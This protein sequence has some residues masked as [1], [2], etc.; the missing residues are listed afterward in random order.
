MMKLFLIVYT[1]GNGEN[2]DQFVWARDRFLA[3][4]EYRNSYELDND[5]VPDCDIRVME[6]PLTPPAEPGIVDWNLINASVRS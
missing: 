3:V 6:V 4:N 2:Q 1:D 5:D